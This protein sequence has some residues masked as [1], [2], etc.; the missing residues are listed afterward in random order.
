MALLGARFYWPQMK[1]EKKRLEHILQR[2][3]RFHASRP[4]KESRKEKRLLRF[5]R[6]IPIPKSLL[7]AAFLWFLAIY[8][9]DWSY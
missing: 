5:L 1:A 6:I 3:A 4:K 8:P 7:K 2:E 9:C